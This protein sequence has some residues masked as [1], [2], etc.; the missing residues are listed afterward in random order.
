M[1]E[2][3]ASSANPRIF[4][5]IA[6]DLDFNEIDYEI[7]KVFE[8]RFNQY[9][10]GYRDTIDLGKD[11]GLESLEILELLHEVNERI[12]ELLSYR[13][14]V[15]VKIDLELNICSTLMVRDFHI[16]LKE[17]LSEKAKIRESIH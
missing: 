13:Y 5:S 15:K 9:M 1:A 6:K 17:H 11:Y 14:D 8:E 4:E 7:K 10:H 2:S 12:S 16:A 3:S